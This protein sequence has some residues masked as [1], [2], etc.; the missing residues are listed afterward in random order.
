MSGS[1]SWNPAPIPRRR[2]GPKGRGGAVRV[3]CVATLVPRKGH[4]VLFRALAALRALPWRLECIGST[5]RAPAE[6]A[7]LGALRRELGL[8]SRI[9]LR[10]ELDEAALEAAWAAADLFV[11]PTLYEG[12]GM[13]VGEA[14]AHGLPVVA[15][16]TGSI[17]AL[18][19]PEA[20]RLVAPGD[21]AAL[22][23]ALR[24]LLQ[25]PSALQACSSAA[26][27]R[28]AAL[29]RWPQAAAEFEQALLRWRH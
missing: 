18:V 7:R 15:S 23:T 6:A 2:A 22:A 28:A 5:T 13:A 20:G 1:S 19:G 21:V 9:A 27:Q 12:H 24:A 8:E 3:L 25:D 26:M 10:G 29:R 11:L 17:A 4:E 16:D 14:I